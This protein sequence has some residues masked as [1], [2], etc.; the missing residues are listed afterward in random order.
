[1]EH[2]AKSSKPLV[3]F[4]FQP[5]KKITFHTTQSTRLA[6]SIGSKGTVLK[7]TQIDGTQTICIRGTGF[8]LLETGE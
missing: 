5:L 3:K 7:G 1:V 6:F 4:Q 8:Q 2:F